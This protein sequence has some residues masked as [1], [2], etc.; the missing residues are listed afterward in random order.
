[1]R[2]KPLKSVWPHT[3]IHLQ[4]THNFVFDLLCFSFPKR[5]KAD[6]EKTEKKLIDF[7][8]MEVSFSISARWAA[9]LTCVVDCRIPFRFTHQS[10]E[11]AFSQHEEATGKSRRQ[12][13][14]DVWIELAEHFNW[15]TSEIKNKYKREKKKMPGQGT[16]RKAA[17]KLSFSHHNLSKLNKVVSCWFRHVCCLR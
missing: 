5:P 10:T 16:S 2:L 6:S 7:R 15:F 3:F 11:V 4:T 8:F 12:K 1:M 14:K 17:D 13:F 9:S